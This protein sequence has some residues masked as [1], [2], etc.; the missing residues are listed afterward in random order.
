MKNTTKLIL[1]SAILATSGWTTTL[2]DDQVNEIFGSDSSG[3]RM[4]TYFTMEGNIDITHKTLTLQRVTTKSG[5]SGS[6]NLTIAGKMKDGR[7][8]TNDTSVE[9][10]YTI[11]LANKGLLNN[12]LFHFG[13]D[14]TKV[15]LTLSNISAPNTCN[16]MFLECL[17][18]TS[19]NLANFNT[20]AVRDMNYM[21]YKCAKLSQLIVP[22]DFPAKSGVNTTREMFYNTGS[23][24]QASSVTI[25]SSKMEGTTISELFSEKLQSK[26]SSLNNVKL[27]ANVALE[28]Y[29]KVKIS[30]KTTEIA[31]MKLEKEDIVG[32]EGNAELH[33]YGSISG[34]SGAGEKAYFRLLGTATS[35]KLIN[36]IYLGLVKNLNIS[37]DD[38]SGPPNYYVLG[39]KVA[40]FDEE[41]IAVQAKITKVSEESNVLINLDK[42]T[43]DVNKNIVVIASETESSDPI[44]IPNNNTEVVVKAALANDTEGL[45][46]GSELHSRNV[47]LSGV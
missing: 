45:T 22:S 20:A 23:A 12:H 31:T 40:T 35:A 34:P 47:K 5:G 3:N 39:L 7:D 30:G 8:V 6:V 21:F 1:T 42:I 16:F 32:F 36:Y 15:N 29:T 27:S 43:D 17:S 10:F 25:Y 18:L 33:N 37:Y 28:R 24:S 41:H 11:T 46:G 38:V 19:L 9:S 44:E 14:T 4:S 2:T 26:V 13:T